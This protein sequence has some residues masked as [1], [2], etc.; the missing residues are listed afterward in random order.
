MK[1][2]LDKLE[3][4][5]LVATWYLEGAQP[6]EIKDRLREKGIEIKSDC[7]RQWLTRRGYTKRRK[8]IEAELD[9]ELSPSKIAQRR[10]ER[11]KDS[12]DRWAAKSESIVDKALD[13]ASESN[14]LRDL[15]VATGAAAQSLKIFQVCAGISTGSNAPGVTVNF[16]F[17]F[18]RGPGSPFHPDAVAK[19]KKEAALS[20]VNTALDV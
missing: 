20:S 11:A 14:R 12:M 1:S 19:R 4:K 5:S 10:L 2:I 17:G 13:A 9:V 15:A 8:E 6:R 18:A 3:T 7:L 16:D